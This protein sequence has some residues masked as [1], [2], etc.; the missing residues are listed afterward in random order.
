MAAASS[1]IS[2]SEPE[3]TVARAPKRHRDGHI[4]SGEAATH[5]HPPKV[6]TGFPWAFAIA[7][8]ILLGIEAA[9]RV[10]PT[11]KNVGY[12]PGENEYPALAAHLD[13]NDVADVV[14]VG[15]SRGR[16][17]ILAPEMARNLEKALGRKLTVAN[18]SVSGGRADQHEAIV[19]RVLRKDRKPLLILYGI[20]ERDLRYNHGIDY[21][22]VALFWNSR[23]LRE[24]VDR[25]GRTAFL[26]GAPFV[27]LNSL[28]RVSYTHRYREQIRTVIERRVFGASDNSPFEGGWSEYQNLVMSDPARRKAIS[29]ARPAAINE[30]SLVNE[31]QSDAE[32]AEYVRR[33]MQGKK[34][35]MDKPLVAALERTLAEANRAGV[36]LVLF[37][38]PASAILRKHLPK[39]AYDNY[40]KTVRNTARG[41]ETPFVT[42]DQLRLRLRDEHFRDKAHLN[43]T[44]AKLLTDALART[45]VVPAL[46]PPEAVVRNPATRPTQASAAGNGAGE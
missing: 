4:V 27:L 18:Y 21:D 16:E 20:A 1:S 46:A 3:A 29:S 11:P 40:L 28:G 22:R 33:Q 30:R 2:S 31:P 26:N 17:S 14:I 36:E 37:E 13:A 12:T 24:A 45:T 34:F 38:T 8:M 5:E 15:S 42:V 43:V 9:W 19:R 32:V 35:P 6:G 41:Q 7:V 39:D 23:D 44:G 25:D 10:V